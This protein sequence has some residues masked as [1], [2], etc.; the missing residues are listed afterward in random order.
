MSRA[1]H[2]C[3][4]EL[5]DDARFCDQCGQSVVPQCPT[6]GAETAPGA[7]FCS[8]CGAALEATA[9][10]VGQEARKIVSVLFADVVGFTEHTERSDPEDVRARLTFF[11]RQMRE[12][13]ERH[14][15]RI[16]KLIGDGVFAVFGA[17]IA[18]E[19]DPERAVRSAL[20]A[21]ESIV[22]LNERHPDLGLRV[23]MSV[24][25]GEAIVQLDTSTPDREGVIGDVVNTA[26]RLEAVA[27]PGSIV[28]DQRTRAAT[29]STIDYA[30]LPPVSLKGKSEPVQIWRAVA[31]RARFGVAVGDAEPTQFVG[32]ERELGLLV[33]ALDRTIERSAS[34]LVTIT[35]EPGVGKSRMLRELMGVVDER[36][37]LLWWRQGRCLPYGDQTTFSA[38]DEL[39][40]AQA[41]ILESE[42]A[43]IAGEKLRV[44]VD[45]LISDEADRSWVTST[46]EPLIGIGGGAGGGADELVPGWRRFFGAMAQQRPLVIVI[47]DLHWAE[48]AMIE[49]LGELA[50]WAFDLPI[51]LVCTARPELYADHPDWGGGHRNGVTIGLDP[52]ADDDVARLL[53]DLLPKRLVDAEL[54]QTLLERC[55]GNPLYAIE[56][57]RLVGEGGELAPPDSVQALIASRLDLLPAG[58]RAIAQTASV[59]GRVFWSKALAFAMS[60]PATAVAAGIREL[61]DRDLV[62]PVRAPSMTGQEEYSF[63]H[64][65][66]RDVAYGQIPRADRATLHEEIARWIEAIVAD[67][68]DVVGILAHH[69][70]RALELRD[71]LGE[72]RPDLRSQA[73]RFTIAAA[74][75]AVRLDVRSAIE[76]YRRAAEL[77]TEEIRRAEIFADVA[78]LE[79]DMAMMDDAHAHY[80]D[81][82]EIFG[83][84]GMTARKAQSDSNRAKA[85]WIQGDKRSSD[86]QHQRAIQ[87]IEGLDDGPE[88]AFVL[89]QYADSLFLAGNWE[90]AAEVGERALA[91]S[92]TF[93][94]PSDVGMALR[95]LGGALASGPDQAR[96]VEMC[97]EAYRIGQDLGDITFPYHANNLHALLQVMEGPEA[98][99]T[100]IEPAVAFLERRGQEATLDFTRSSR[101]ESLGWLGRWDEAESELTDIIDRDL[102]RGGTQI[103]TMA[104]MQLMLIL[105]Y[106]SRYAEAYD[107]L[108][109]TMDRAREI[110]DPQVLLPSL[111][112]AI[113]AAARAGHVDEARTLIGELEA[114]AFDRSASTLLAMALLPG[115]DLMAE[116]DGP[117]LERM[118]ATA[119]RRF[120]TA[121][122]SL[123]ACLGVI[124]QAHGRHRDAVD[125]LSGAAVGFERLNARVQ[126]HQCR[127]LEARSRLQ[128]GEKDAVAQLLETAGAFF[129]PIGGRYFVDAIESI[130]SEAAG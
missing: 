123:D 66:V 44:A 69:Y 126:E 83:R 45:A 76:L 19:D 50:G 112:A 54:R 55:G 106:R 124:D 14:G 120:P 97:R 95:T 109:P 35:G 26:S 129:T 84:L 115:V 49:F 3:A 52:L 116:L 32:R 59:V 98:A 91:V 48:P 4:V 34:Q 33:D 70:D 74:E 11:H 67:N 113:P 110:Q 2:H 56:Y 68:D 10:S 31:A 111:S 87:A 21:Q 117:A 13:V 43:R 25:T 40:K 53:A 65:L 7:R 73:L 101:V 100:V 105:V 36:P 122:H 46:L 94:S 22:G 62:W 89:R 125:R 24:T 63:R 102:A 18:H 61:V 17:P 128:L 78:V 130:R 80:D 93:S 127:I 118:V 81:A 41:G 108:S 9:P 92:R 85:F 114:L 60:V 8:S 47:E 79:M 119:E 96:G 30:P 57:A 20:R 39:V 51:L 58:A 5:A 72:A 86:E 42:P 71:S 12:D 75:R 99:I 29:S 1:C 38:L 15:G 37:D 6:C 121:N 107:M 88:V 103:V 23:R 90:A 28:V 16:E 104:R 27:E 82:T 64:I 77:T